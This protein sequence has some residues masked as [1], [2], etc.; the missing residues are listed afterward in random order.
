MPRPPHPPR[1]YNS[2]YTW[3]RVQIM[4]LLVISYSYIENNILNDNIIQHLN[5]NRYFSKANVRF[6]LVSGMPALQFRGESSWVPVSLLVQSYS[7]IIVALCSRLSG[8]MCE[9]LCGFCSRYGL[10]MGLL[11]CIRGTWHEAG[12]HFSVWVMVIRV[13]CSLFEC[14]ILAHAWIV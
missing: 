13:T 7:W 2:N 6:D 4:K 9:Y 12:N 14:I 3:W 1:L 10:E 5:S 11:C 8:R